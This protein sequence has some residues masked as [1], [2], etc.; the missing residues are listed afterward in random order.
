MS[1][2]F[3]GK[4]CSRLREYMN[5]EAADGLVGEPLIPLGRMIPTGNRREDAYQFLCFRGADGNSKV[6]LFGC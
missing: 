3:Q 5:E 2:E 6:I 1:F 4:T